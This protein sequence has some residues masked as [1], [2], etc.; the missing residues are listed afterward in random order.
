MIYEV[1]KDQQT[2]GVDGGNFQ[3]VITYLIFTDATDGPEVFADFSALTELDVPIYGDVHPTIV[4]K[5]GT[6]LPVSGITFERRDERNFR[7]T[8]SIATAPANALLAG[9][10]YV[11][12]YGLTSTSDSNASANAS[13]N[14]LIN[15]SSADSLNLSTITYDVYDAKQY[16]DTDVLFP[17]GSV[18]NALGELMPGVRKVHNAVL[19]FTYRV[20]SFDPDW[21][22]LYI[23]SMNSSK[24]T[25]CGITINQYMA[26]LTK[27]SAEYVTSTGMN[28]YLVSAEVEINVMRAVGVEKVLG[29]SY[30]AK[31]TS[32]ENVV[33]KVYVQRVDTI[34]DKDILEAEVLPDGTKVGDTFAGYYSGGPYGYWG[35]YYG[36]DKRIQEPIVLTKDGEIY[37]TTGFPDMEDTNLNI[38]QKKTA[39]KANWGALGLPTRGFNT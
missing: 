34:S 14:A 1:V 28:H 6:G 4:T 36:R 23:G 19:T 27:L 18:V 8:Q 2:G 22:P 32:P 37:T 16:K 21:I 33:E 11:V 17:T 30:Y 31:M 5:Y 39:R 38:I 9:W 29:Q 15:S 7:A 25:I 24:E 26:L 35:E 3:A 13:A 12:T 20:S 10:D